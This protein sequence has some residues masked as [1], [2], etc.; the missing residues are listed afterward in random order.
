MWR[1][2]L[3]DHACSM[4]K[5]SVSEKNDLLEK[6]RRLRIRIAAYDKLVA[7][8]DVFQNGDLEIEDLVTE[9]VEDGIELSDDSDEEAEEEGHPEHAAIFLPSRI[10]KVERE[11]RGLAEMARQEAALR[12]GQINDCLQGLRMALGEKSIM[13]RTQVRN[14]DSQHQMTRAW[15]SINKVEAQ[16][17]RHVKRY[18]QAKKALVNLE[19]ANPQ[20]QDITKEDLRMPG[21]ITH[22]NR[23]DQRSDT[24]AWFWRL[25]PQ[26]GGGNLED[27]PK[28][29]ECK[30]FLHVK[31]YILLTISFSVYRVNWTRASARSERWREEVVLLQHEMKWTVEYFRRQEEVWLDREKAVEGDGP[32]HDGLRSYAAKQGYMW[33]QMAAQANS[34]FNKY[35]EKY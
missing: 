34:I 5:T 10:S 8:L 7:K 3:A 26:L 24:M 9:G 6:R 29:E 25:D 11:N 23:V 32:E 20:F 12:V 2:S 28:M 21:D 30:F 15:A 14:A 27:N 4:K 17:H 18:Q 13:L 22:E 35:R 33:Q 19:S 31:T 1:L 16:V